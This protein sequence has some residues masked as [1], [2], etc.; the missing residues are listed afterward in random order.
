M[1]K[2]FGMK[3]LHLRLSEICSPLV[4]TYTLAKNGRISAAVKLFNKMWEKGINPDVAIC[5]CVI[6]QLCFKKK[7]PE[8]L[9][10]FW[11]DE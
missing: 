1:L 4:H 7:I 11:R 2:G 10:I 8:A 6:D 3:S 5:N 9:E